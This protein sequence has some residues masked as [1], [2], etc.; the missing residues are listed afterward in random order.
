M[1]FEN[2]KVVTISIKNRLNFKI[3]GQKYQTFISENLQDKC[4][5]SY[6]SALS[7]KQGKKSKKFL[8]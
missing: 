7:W 3:S 6:F 5:I 1:L 8:H 4:V 2:I